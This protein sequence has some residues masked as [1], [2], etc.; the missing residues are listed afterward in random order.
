MDPQSETKNIPGT[1]NRIHPPFFGPHILAKIK[2]FLSINMHNKLVSCSLTL[3]HTLHFVRCQSSPRESAI[4]FTKS[5]KRKRTS[6]NFLFCLIAK[7]EIKHYLMKLT[8]AA[9]KRNL[10]IL[11]LVWNEI[12]THF[13]CHR[14]RGNQHK[15]ILFFIWGANSKSKRWFF[16][17]FSQFLEPGF[18]KSRI[19][20]SSK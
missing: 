8:W 5:S 11:H 10:K 15:N 13:R 7:S 20:G 1:S 2:H 3:K 16:Y 18:N 6:L 9:S 19:A 12:G 14:G 17:W 4:I